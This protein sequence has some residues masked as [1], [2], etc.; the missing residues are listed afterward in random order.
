MAAMGEWRI[1]WRRVDLS[2]QLVRRLVVQLRASIRPVAQD[3]VLFLLC[4]MVVSF[5]DSLVLG[6]I[7]GERLVQDMPGCRAFGAKYCS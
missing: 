6:W 4:R 1:S 2:T 7:S 3:L 5:M